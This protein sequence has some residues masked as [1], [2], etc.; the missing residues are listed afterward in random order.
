MLTPAE[1]ESTLQIEYELRLEALGEHTLRDIADDIAALK[2]FAPPYHLSDA[3]L[4]GIAR[5]TLAEM[6]TRKPARAAEAAHA[7]TQPSWAF[8]WL[9]ASFWGLAKTRD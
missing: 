1:I 9:L 3:E 6:Q 5:A 7:P 4:P 2:R 8:P